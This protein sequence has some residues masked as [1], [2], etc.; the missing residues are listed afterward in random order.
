MLCHGLHDLHEGSCG[1]GGLAL[2]GHPLHLLTLPLPLPLPPT[3]LQEQLRGE[4]RRGRGTAAGWSHTRHP[5]A[6]PPAPPHP[7]TLP[8]SGSCSSGS[9][10]RRRGR[11]A[12]HPSPPHPPPPYPPPHGCRETKEEGVGVRILCSSL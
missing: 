10:R 7:H 8:P 6:T 3:L 9:E 4:E 1:S 11:E 5:S 12:H 2:A